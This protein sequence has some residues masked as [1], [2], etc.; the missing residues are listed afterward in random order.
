MY[1]SGTCPV[2]S[3]AASPNPDV[4]LCAP[5]FFSAHKPEVL[6]ANFSFLLQALKKYGRVIITL[7]AEQEKKETQIYRTVF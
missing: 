1:T 2:H 6:S 3:P 4:G 7:Y 5:A